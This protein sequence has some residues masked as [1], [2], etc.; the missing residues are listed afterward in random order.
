VGNTVLAASRVLPRT[1]GAARLATENPFA[2]A[3]PQPSPFVP[4]V[5]GNID[6]CEENPGERTSLPIMTGI[7]YLRGLTRN[8]GLAAIG[9][10]PVYP[11]PLRTVLIK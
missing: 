1:T 11:L 4:I 9:A 6:L 2:V 7:Y 5:T 10:G 8:A 3:G